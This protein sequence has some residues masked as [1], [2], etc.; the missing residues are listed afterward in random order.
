[1]SYPGRNYLHIQ[2]CENL[3]S[4]RKIHIHNE[5]YCRMFWS[6]KTLPYYKRVKTDVMDGGKCFHNLHIPIL[7]PCNLETWHIL[8]GNT[9]FVDGRMCVGRC[10]SVNCARGSVLD[11][12][13]PQ[14]GVPFMTHFSKKSMYHLVAKF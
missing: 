1:M 6:V 9:F 12:L 13:L 14:K 3:E 10:L 5:Y 4:H 2:Y 7:F 11:G 8:L